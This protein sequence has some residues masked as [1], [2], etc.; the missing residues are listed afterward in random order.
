MMLVREVNEYN[1]GEKEE[2]IV[3][4]CA[5]L[6]ADA[7]AGVVKRKQ[8]K[9]LLVASCRFGSPRAVYAGAPLGMWPS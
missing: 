4:H 1:C 9:T 8:R 7:E 5:A 6:R 2:V 3:L